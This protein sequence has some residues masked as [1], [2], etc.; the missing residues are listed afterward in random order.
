MA[1]AD[2]ISYFCSMGYN[3]SAIS[4]LTQDKTECPTQDQISILDL[5]LPSITVPAL[6]NWTTV[7]RTVTNVGNLTSVYRVVIDPPIGTRVEVEPPVLAFNATVRKLSF[8]V[9][10]WSLLEMDYGFS[11]GS[12][13]WS[14]GVHL[15]QS[16]LSVRIQI[17]SPFH[18]Y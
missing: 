1:T 4:V 6:S 3:N 17:Q 12:I 5:N 14:D 7:T 18:L 13:I 11:F 9:T 8:K 2:Y 16:P 15:V 10:I